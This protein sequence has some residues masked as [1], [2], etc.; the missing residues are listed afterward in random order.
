[1]PV[2]ASGAPVL[3]EFSVSS[4]ASGSTAAQLLIPPYPGPKGGPPY[5]YNA[6]AS[7]APSLTSAPLATKANWLTAPL[8]GVTKITS[9]LVNASS[10]GHTLFIL[11]P[12]NWTY[13]PAGLAKNTTA[14]PNGS[15]SSSTGLFDDPGVYSTN[16]KYPTAGAV[17]P[18]PAADAAI[19][20]TN[21]LVCYQLSDGTWQLDTIASGTFG[22]SLTLTTGTPNRNGGAILAGAPLFYFGAVAGTLV[23]PATG[24]T[25]F[26]TTTKTSAQTG[27]QDYLDSVFS[28][29][30]PGDPLLIYDA[31]ATAADSIIASGVYGAY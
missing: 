17:F 20:G 29:V 15:G 19:S 28:A 14:I 3:G 9:L 23:D 24:S 13:F 10:T 31:N 25:A 11:R 16:Y 27:Y 30:H 5:L 4:I 2:G 6:L 18:A 1:M 12:L 21:L 22:A 7:Y 8:F 26:G